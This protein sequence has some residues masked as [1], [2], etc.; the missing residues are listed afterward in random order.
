MGKKVYVI[1]LDGATFDLIIPWLNKLPNI[2]KLIS[3]GVSGPLESTIPPITCP[4]WL[5]F[6]TGEGPGDL[7]VFDFNDH[8]I[9][10]YKTKIINPSRVRIF[11]K[12]LWRILS[13]NRK[14]IGIINV[15]FTYPPTEINGFIIS[16]MFTPSEK[17]NYTYPPE[18]KN[19][20]KQQIGQIKFDIERNDEE[21]FLKDVY[22]NLETLKKSIEFLIKEYNP[23]FFMTVFRETDAVQHYMWRHMDQN[24]PLYDEKKSKKYRDSI[25][26]VWIKIDSIIGVLLKKIDNDSII[27]LM[28]DHGFGP[29]DKIFYIN[30]W[31]EQ[32]GY[33]K[34]T[35]F[36]R[37][38][39]LFNKI[40]RKILPQSKQ[41]SFEELIDWSKTS[42][43]S[44]SHTSA[45]GQIYL[46]VIDREPKGII[47]TGTIYEEI[48]SRIIKNLYELINPTTLSKFKV[49][50]YRREDVYSGK[51]LS[52]APDIIYFIDDLN[53]IQNY[54]FYPN[55]VIELKSDL[56]QNATHRMNGIF[57]VKGQNI[58]KN[59]KI[60]DAKIIDI[61]P[62][63]LHI[64]EVPIPSTMKGKILNNIFEK[65]NFEIS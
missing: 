29:R 10:E 60:I 26:N 40:I 42:A 36:A 61:A 64:M 34:L 30:N 48:R 53:C 63:I 39:L 25:L 9:G 49:E 33:L 4:A 35:N 2:S 37:S 16:G 15:P 1:G 28:S 5:C 22:D 45:F 8:N 21:Q 51:Y 11:S 6:M 18:L 13:N 50:A 27:I 19:M 20:L 7:G 47:Q 57:I 24:H 31:L 65:N 59:K 44:P 38:K 46:N 17:S 54:K 12:P 43:Y 41:I 62:T 52:K 23:E 55:K 58:Q 56:K 14:K 32:N 3:E